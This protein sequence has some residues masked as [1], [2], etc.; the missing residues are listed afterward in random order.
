MVL[1]ATPN[2]GGYIML[3]ISKLTDYATVIMSYLALTPKDVVSAAQIARAVHVSLPTVSKI[4]KI[5]C[6]GELVISFRG[7]GGGY[8]LARPT[9]KITVAEVVTAIEG[10][11]AMTE[12]CLSEK[13]CAIDSLCSIK[14]NWKVI[15]KIIL[16]ALAGLT[17]QDMM[18][19]LTGHSLTL[20]GIP[21]MVKGF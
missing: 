18:R 13:L 8:Q 1:Y 3:R 14:E 6:D 9:E 15:N 10:K 21:I 2:L 4:L 16:T 11:L 20:K 7:T 5:L 19:P 12:C 17:L